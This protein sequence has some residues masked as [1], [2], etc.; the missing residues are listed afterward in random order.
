MVKTDEQI[1]GVLH[2]DITQLHLVLLSDK[3]IQVEI[4]MMYVIVQTK[5]SVL[6]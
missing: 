6:V 1:Q 4:P 3:H 2:Q 5:L